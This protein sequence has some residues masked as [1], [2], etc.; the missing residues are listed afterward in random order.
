[1]NICLDISPA[2]RHR[3]GIG[4]YVVEL[5]TAMLESGDR[6][7]LTGFYNG[8]TV[9]KLDAPLHTLPI[10]R[11]QLP[12]KPWR[13][14]VMAAHTLRAAQ[15]KRFDDIDLFHA[16]DNLLPYFRH[17][18]SVLTIYDLAF[19][20]FPETHTSLNRLYLRLM[21]PRFIKRANRVI[22]ISETT[23][24]DLQRFY[25][26]DPA[27]L[28]VIP[29]GVNPSFRYITDAAQRAAI[30]HRYGLP[31]RFCLFVGTLEPR[32]NLI[33]LIDAFLL[34][35]VDDL[36]L[37]V[38]GR[39]GWGLEPIQQRLQAA[40]ATGK[41]IWTD[42]I[43]GADLSTLYS[44]AEFLVFPSLYEGFGLPILEAMACSVPVITSAR[45]AMSEVAGDAA[46]LVDPDQ[47]ESIAQAIIELAASPARRDDLRARGL[48]RAKAYTWHTTAAA[49]LA[50][51][52]ELI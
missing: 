20:I 16:T 12:D 47:D 25:G 24:T 38:V 15:D 8:R 46:L 13:A 11:S 4:R 14:L 28:H 27:K 51:Y 33:K 23:A 49:T 52:R 7:Q 44:L 43:P 1:M 18:N 48:Q 5:V 40:A 19:R 17:L 3:G 45:S 39:A 37:V 34:A 31:A 21:L 35:A 9:P 22:C 2:V 32:K 42:S 50:V 41:V 10:S 30:R 6:E 26:V 36:C 29:L